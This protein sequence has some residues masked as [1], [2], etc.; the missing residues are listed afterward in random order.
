MCW[1]SALYVASFAVNDKCKCSKSES[2]SKMDNG[3][4]DVEAP[5]TTAGKIKSGFS[6]M[7]NRMSNT[8]KKNPFSRGGGEDETESAAAVNV[9]MKKKTSFNPFSRNSND[10]EEAAQP[11]EVKKK[12]SFN[13]FSRSRDD[14]EEKQP[15]KPS[16]SSSANPFRR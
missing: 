1:R 12:T 5:K 13:P 6:N 7:G 8:F 16:G 10:N 3:N 15:P 11:K 4:S 2:Y 14:D 9:E